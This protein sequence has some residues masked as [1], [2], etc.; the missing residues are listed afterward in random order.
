[1]R[2][3]AT[4]AEVRDA[5][6]RLPAVIAGL[7]PDVNGVGR[8]LQLRIGVTA[9]SQI[10]QAFITKTRGGIGS[11]GIKWKPLKPATIAQRR[12]TRTERKAAGVGGKRVR[13]LLTP[14]QDKQW[15]RT[16]AS[17]KARLMLRGMSEGA[18][19]ALAAQLAWTEAK[20]AG[21]K[22]LIGTFGNRKVDIGRDTS[23][24][25]RSLT[26]GVED[27][28]SGAASQVFDVERGAV[29]VGTAIPYASHFHKHRPLWPDA[30]PRVW[31]DAILAS[32]GR[33]VARLMALYLAGAVRR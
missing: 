26:P 30:L 20:A 17:K 28:P 11:D 33:G 19:S 10:Q 15:R 23:V 24:M 8:A 5:L 32:L 16:F 2:L 6:A 22:T 1:M 27:R 3:R 29:I 18:A 31:W 7:A 21:A 9:L 13:G 4:E 12:T 25:F 14:S